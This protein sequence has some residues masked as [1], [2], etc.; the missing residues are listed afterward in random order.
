[1]RFE[2]FKEYN[3]FTHIIELIV[4]NRNNIF[5][6][7]KTRKFKSFSVSLILKLFL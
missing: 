1:M 2:F 4:I 7:L 5:Y 3:I 6:F